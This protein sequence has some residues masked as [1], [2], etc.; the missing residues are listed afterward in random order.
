[1][2]NYTYNDIIMSLTEKLTEQGFSNAHWEARELAGC[3]LGINARGRI[4]GRTE[5]TPAQIKSCALLLA[6]R[7]SHEPLQYIIGEWDFYGRTFD[8]GE[9]V[10]I[11]RSDTET[12]IDAAKKLCGDRTGLTVIDLCAGTGCI[13]ITLEKE[14]DTAEVYCVEKYDMAADYLKRNIKKLGS[15]AKPVIGDVLDRATAES[16]PKADLIACNPPYINAEDMKCLQKEVTFEP[17]TALDGGEDG[18]DFYRGIVRIWADRLTPDGVMLFEIG[19]GQEEEVME[20]MI[21]A[22]LKDVRVRRDMAGINRAV[23]GRNI[24]SR[25]VNLYD[26]LEKR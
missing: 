8:V 1:M 21:Q 18:F 2:V 14:L 23:M 17:A 3:A 25:N 11:P 9:G 6:R 22:G 13:G 20:I 19:A 5:A 24:E 10:L 16:L 15:S 4:E 12:L 7:L 26:E